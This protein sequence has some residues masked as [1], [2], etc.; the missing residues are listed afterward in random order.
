MY[1]WYV[2]VGEF[3]VM[4]SFVEPLPEKFKIRN[5]NALE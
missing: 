3:M 5:E 2:C 4:A 1:V